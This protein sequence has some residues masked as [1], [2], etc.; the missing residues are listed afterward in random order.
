MESTT[1]AYDNMVGKRYGHL[2]VTVVGLKNHRKELC[3]ACTCDCGRN[4]KLSIASLLR[5]SATACRSPLCQWSDLDYSLDI[6][7]KH[8]G[9]D[10]RLSKMRVPVPLNARQHYILDRDSYD[11][12]TRIVTGDRDSVIIQLEAIG[13]DLIV[14]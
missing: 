7:P 10:V 14:L 12:P 13:Y 3:A 11:R 6:S 9:K 5:G 4:V 8:I 2:S 1:V